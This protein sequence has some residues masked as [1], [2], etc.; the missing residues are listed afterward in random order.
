MHILYLQNGNMLIQ[1]EGQY[2][3]CTGTAVTDDSAIPMER[4]TYG[5]TIATVLIMILL[6][7]IIQLFLWNN[8]NS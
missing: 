4:S 8:T 6:F 1:Y 7:C 2:Y 5:D 3:S